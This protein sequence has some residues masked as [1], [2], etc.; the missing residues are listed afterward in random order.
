LPEIP[1][2]YF[3]GISKRLPRA[4]RGYVP[5]PFK[6]YLSGTQLNLETPSDFDPCEGAFG[7][8]RSL[9]HGCTLGPGDQ[10]TAT[11]NT[12]KLLGMVENGNIA[13]LVKA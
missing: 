3:T 7:V 6:L 5:I 4:R 8:D 13:E 12:Q 1:Q 9:A 11:R 2:T 10:Y